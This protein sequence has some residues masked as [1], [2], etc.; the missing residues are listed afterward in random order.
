M[1]GNCSLHGLRGGS[2]GNKSTYVRPSSRFRYD[3]D[4]R[5]EANGFRV[6]RELR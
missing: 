4:V 2:F 6:L 3:S 5:Y 1:K